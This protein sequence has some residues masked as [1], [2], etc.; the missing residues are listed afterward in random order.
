MRKL[1]NFKGGYSTELVNVIFKAGKPFVSATIDP[2][3]IYHYNADERRRTDELEAYRVY[4]AQPGVQN[5]VPVK[6]MTTTDKPKVPFGQ[7]VVLD[8]LEACEVQGHYYLR[9]AAIEAVKEG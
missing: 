4:V 7:T 5:P 1:Q 6:I 3:P 2:E 8:T 9:A